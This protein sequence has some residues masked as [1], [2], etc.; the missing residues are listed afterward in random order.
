[1]KIDDGS[2][3]GARAYSLRQSGPLEC[4]WLGIAKM[5]D[6][7]PEMDDVDGRVNLIINLAKQYAR[8]RGLPWPPKRGQ[9]T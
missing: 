9:E 6:Y 2:S 3:F 7:R 4:T 8:W 1:M 5:L